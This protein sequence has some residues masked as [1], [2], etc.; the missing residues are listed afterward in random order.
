[1]IETTRDESGEQVS[2]QMKWV[3]LGKEQGS[4]EKSQ[5][6]RQDDGGMVEGFTA[7]FKAFRAVMSPN[8]V[9]ER[10]V[11]GEN[12]RRKKSKKVDRWGLSMV[13]KLRSGG[14]QIIESEV[15]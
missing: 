15:K 12:W 11:E 9:A 3:S 1:M 13:A 5:L 14:D 6:S 8:R 10:T 2:P 4:E 7:A